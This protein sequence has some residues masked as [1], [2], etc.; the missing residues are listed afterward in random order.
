MKRYLIP[1]I[2]ALLLLGVAGWFF[3]PALINR[4]RSPEYIYKRLIELAYDP[5]LGQLYDELKIATNAKM[6][7][8]RRETDGTRPLDIAA[9]RNQP[10]S[11]A[12][13]IVAGAN[14]N[15]QNSIGDTVIHIAVRNH[16]VSVLKELR[17]FMPD[18]TL[19]NHD[20]LTAIEL[21][22]QINDEDAANALLA[23]FSQ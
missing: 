17:R 3:G 16:A 13:F 14:I 2:V 12:A 4:E 23:P 11:A 10:L 22:H 1:L 8:D 20:G 9:S 6:N 19:K 15:A 7:I 21:A 5:R 18:L